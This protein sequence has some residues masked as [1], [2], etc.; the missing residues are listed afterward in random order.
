VAILKKEEFDN[1]FVCG[2]TLIDGSHILTAAHCVKK[3]QPG[4][5]RSVTIYVQPLH[6]YLHT[7]GDIGGLFTRFFLS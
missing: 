4:Q 6:M 3:Y 5:L 2:G 1:V 7:T